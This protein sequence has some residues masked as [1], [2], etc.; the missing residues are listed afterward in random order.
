MAAAVSSPDPLR[1]PQAGL[2]NLGLPPDILH[3]IERTNALRLLKATE[4]V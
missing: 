4:T 2:A 1:L 3:A